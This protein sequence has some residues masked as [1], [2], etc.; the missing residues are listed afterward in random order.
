MKTIN[1][2]IWLSSVLVL[3]LTACKKNDL[4]N[5]GVAEK[6]Y[7]TEEMV[8]SDSISSVATMKVDGKQFIKSANV[9]MEV[10]NVY[11][12]TVKIEDLTKEMNGFVSS[13]NLQSNILSEETFNTSDKEAML[14]KKYQSENS[15]EVRVPT[16]KL[17]EFLQAIHKNSLFLNSR[18]IQAEDVSANIKFAEME[19]KRVAT[20]G[21]NIATLK[22]NSEK[23][24]LNNENKIDENQQQLQ[25]LQI[26][27][28]LKYSVV[29][30]YIKEPKVSIAEIPVTNVKNK[31]NQYKFNFWYDIKNALIEGYY[32]IQILLVGLVRIWP[33]VVVG[34]ASFLL[35]KK[36]KKNTNNK[37]Q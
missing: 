34:L 21:K 20:N 35:Y 2:K 12:A 9:S 22:N 37:N 1:S 25:S 29:N 6:A 27:D 18:T 31:D 33:I 11:K 4:Q 28:K 19:A 36:F 16:N 30:I 17:G 23:V 5:S 15:M 24:N 7:S 14:V 3:S 8:V 32:L 10:E 13:S 26:T